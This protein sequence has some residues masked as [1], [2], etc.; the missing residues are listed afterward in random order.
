MFDS[1]QLLIFHSYFRWIVLLIMLVQLVWIL[2]NDKQHKIFT[3][4]DF[5]IL[6]LFTGIFN[7]QLILGWALYLNSI[8]VDSF[9]Q[10]VAKGIKNRQLRFFG[11]EHMSMM[12]LAIV[13]LN[14]TTFRTRHRINKRDSFRFLWKNYLWIVLIILSSIPWS[15]SPL[16]SRPNFR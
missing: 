3:T 14:I 9:W 5:K 7:I 13:M 16:T 2:V 10:D 11:L 6:L 15:F 12:T 8:L 4:K 1:S